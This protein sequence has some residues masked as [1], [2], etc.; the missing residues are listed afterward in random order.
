MA[1]SSIRSLKTKFFLAIGVIIFA[2]IVEYIITAISGAETGGQ[3][4]FGKIPNYL[5]FAANTLILAALGVIIFFVFRPA[6][7]TLSS[8]EQI[9]GNSETLS[10]KTLDTVREERDR[11][12]QATDMKDKVVSLIA[13]DLKNP[14]GAIRGFSEF[15]LVD[16]RFPLS[17]HHRDAIQNIYDQSDNML[18]LIADVMDISRLQTGNFVI[19]YVFMDAYYVVE[20]I[21]R[22]LLP[23]ASAKQVTLVNKV[24][25]GTRIYG[26]STLLGQVLQN[27]LTNAIKFSHPS[28][29]VHIQLEEPKDPET[30]SI[31]VR[32]FGIG[33]SEKAI[34]NLFKLEEKTSTD[35][36]SGEKGT[37]FGL[38]LTHQIMT[39]H[40]GDL[41]AS[42][43][44]G[45]GSTFSIILRQE[46]PKVLVVDDDPIFRKI[47]GQYLLPMQVDITECENGGD[48]WN[49][50]TGGFRPHLIISDIQ[51]PVRNGFDLLVDIRMTVKLSQIPV[52]MVTGDSNEKTR[53]RVLRLGAQDF[54]SKPIDPGDFVPRVR[55]F[56][57]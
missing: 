4:Q 40:K 31:A 41:H 51:M 28:S 21:L 46:I 38:P 2:L 12:Q 11:A 25:S 23:M 9:S 30:I 22:R 24:P 49:L 54:V 8:S 50:L 53:E 45:E 37:G 35:G 43:C 19:T 26:D 14:L 47:I 5:S 57:A 32:D 39:A 29:E 27:L 17:D 42:S 20:K 48:A 3:E 34:G 44:E 7:R 10:Q 6:F 16:E 15:M 56:I 13:H 55:Q 36:T 33:V 1:P 18:M 52:I